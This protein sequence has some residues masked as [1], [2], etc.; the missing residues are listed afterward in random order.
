MCNECP[1]N[2]K[3]SVIKRLLKELDEKSKDTLSH[4]YNVVNYATGF[5]RYIKCSQEEVVNLHYAALLHDIGKIKIP[6]EILDKVERLTQEEYEIIKSHSY[7]GYEIVQHTGVFS[8][9]LEL[10]LHHHERIDGN[11]YPHKLVNNNI[12]KL[13]KILSIC[14]SFDAMVSKRTYKAS[15]TIEEAIKELVNNV[16]KQFDRELVHLFVVFIKNFEL[17]ENNYYSKMDVL[18]NDL[19]FLPGTL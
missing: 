14:D 17:K 10:I 8:E 13:C 7:Y 2:N 16:E 4:C 1:E 18:N 19:N 5:A 12:S 15:M 9:E 11:G 6:S 3:V